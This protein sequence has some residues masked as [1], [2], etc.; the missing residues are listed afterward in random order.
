MRVG[1]EQSDGTLAWGLDQLFYDNGVGKASELSTRP[2]HRPVHQ[3][4]T[5]NA[6]RPR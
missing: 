4:S 2:I 1:L 5:T 3:P 6:T